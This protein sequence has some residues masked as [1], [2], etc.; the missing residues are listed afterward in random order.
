MGLSGIVPAGIYKGC[1]VQ[2]TP[3]AGAVETAECAP[4]AG[5]TSFYPDKL[6]LS[7]YTNTAALIKAYNDARAAAGVGKDFGRCDRTSWGGEG[8][9]VHPGVPAKPGG[10]R[11][12]YFDGNNAVMV[13]AHEKLGQPTHV[14][15]L[16]IAREG[17]TD[18]SRLY[19]WWNFWIHLMGKCLQEG[20]TASAN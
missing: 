17:G 19:S 3:T 2:P 15:F 18:H 8:A 16:G 7:T 14:N 1:T 6:E 11:F 10:R 12:C 20:C 5:Q 13:W 4:P 9:W